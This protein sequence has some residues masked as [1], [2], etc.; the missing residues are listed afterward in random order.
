VVRSLIRRGQKPILAVDADPNSNLAGAL[1]I[2]IEETVGQVLE[3][4][5]GKKLTIPMGMSKQAFLELRLNQAIA[6]TKDLDLL[7]MGRPEGQG[8]YC[9]A[10][11]VLRDMIERLTENY[12]YVVLDNEAGMEHLSRRTAHRIDA[13]LMVSDP[14]MKGMRTVRT[15]I[16]LVQELAL[17]VANKYLVVSRT[18]E[19]DPRLAELA[20]E[21][22]VPLIGTVPED[23][24]VTEQDLSMK[25]FVELA[26]SSKAAAAVDEIVG[27]LLAG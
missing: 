6:E 11:A 3:E 10:N 20:A 17:P 23:P 27:K 12:Q 25:T 5:H 21:L 19:L 9:S 8:C 16:D 4:F 14:S 2:K 24:A 1:G 15:L 13:L 22:P 26:E 7:V 18:A